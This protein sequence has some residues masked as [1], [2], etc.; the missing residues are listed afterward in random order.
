MFYNVL[1]TCSKEK[2]D[3]RTWFSSK[4]EPSE[5][6]FLAG[7]IESCFWFGNSRVIASIVLTNEKLFIK[8]V[9]QYLFKNFWDNSLRKKKTKN[10]WSSR[11]MT[12]KEHELVTVMNLF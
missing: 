6:E 8:G 2:A 5:K 3:L 12:A 11:K 7:Y 4:S 9:P 10:F 1:A